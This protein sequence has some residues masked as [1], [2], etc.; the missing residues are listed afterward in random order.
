[1]L[2]W[3]Y[4]DFFITILKSGLF[5][6]LVDTRECK[7]DL[8]RKPRPE[9][10][11]K[12]GKSLQLWNYC[13]ILRSKDKCLESFKL[14]TYWLILRTVEPMFVML[15]ATRR[16]WRSLFS[17][18]NYVILFENTTSSDHIIIKG[19]SLSPNNIVSNFWMIFIADPPEVMIE[20]IHL[21]SQQGRQEFWV[22]WIQ[23]TLE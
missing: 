3:G 10:S 20:Q 11:H 8:L 22:R 6:D 5:S 4:N 19:A 13:C 18:S 12:E 14:W 9:D 7:Q 21:T 2:R 16:L 17:V 1:M 23:T 15:T